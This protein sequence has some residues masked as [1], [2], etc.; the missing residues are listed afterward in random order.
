MAAWRSG[1]ESGWHAGRVTQL[2]PAW[3][4]HKVNVK[5]MGSASNINIKSCCHNI[6]G[7]TAE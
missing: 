7:T 6:D 5:G 4:T 3:T 2:G 1:Y